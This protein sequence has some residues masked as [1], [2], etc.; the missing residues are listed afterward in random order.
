M[1]SSCQKPSNTRE[2]QAVRILRV[3]NSGDPTTPV[4]M[5]ARQKGPGRDPF[6]SAL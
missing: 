5:P 4:E 1:S 3:E 6:N 2:V